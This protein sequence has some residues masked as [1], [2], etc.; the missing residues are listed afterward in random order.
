[1]A[2]VQE[3]LIKEKSELQQ[4]VSVTGELTV[5]SLL[6]DFLDVQ[7][8]DLATILG[9]AFYAQVK[10]WYYTSYASGSKEAECIFRCQKI[11]A[12]LALAQ[13]QNIGQL[14][15]SDAGYTQQK[16]Q[17]TES[18]KQWQMDDL[19]D[20]LYFKGYR[21]IDNLLKFLET[22][23]AYFTTWA[24]DASAYTINK[25]FIVQS[26]DQMQEYHD[27]QKSRQTYLSLLSTFKT[28][29]LFTI[30]PAIGTATFERIKTE[31]AAADISTDVNKILPFLIGACTKFAIVKACEQNLV[32]IRN[33]G[34]Y[35]RS[36]RANNGNNRERSSAKSDE[37]FR[38]KESCQT[39]AQQYLKKAVD[40]LQANASD[41]VFPEFYT[42]DIY[43]T[44]DDQDKIDYDNTLDKNIFLM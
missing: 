13:Y 35:V 24:S 44:S 15:I 6:P 30:E 11:V 17:T 36:M 26:A 43:I 39:D 4:H 27:I 3:I 34:L 8:N 22:N 7:E 31:I 37:L 41:T 25:K 33:N 2:E 16:T 23:K 29:E 32:E 1:M 18:G 14:K 5:E 38:L 28:V 20:Y 19:R 42:A 12:N 10:E 21:A 9:D 40:Y